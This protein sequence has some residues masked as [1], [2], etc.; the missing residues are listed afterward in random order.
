MTFYVVAWTGGYETASYAYAATEEEALTKAGAWE[1]DR[2]PED[3]IIEVLVI[4]T[5]AGTVERL[6]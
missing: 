2:Q 1:A 5:Q 4:D 3:D 6:V